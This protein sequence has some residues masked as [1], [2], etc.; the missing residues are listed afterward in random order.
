MFLEELASG[1]RSISSKRNYWFI[2]TYG[3]SVF[4][5][6]HERGYVGIGLNSVPISLI[7]SAAD[8][9]VAQTEELKIFL[10]NR[11]NMILQNATRWS[12]QLVTFYR[13]IVVG[14]VIIIPDENSSHFAIGEVTSDVFQVKKVGTFKDKKG[15]AEQFPQKRRKVNWLRVESR[16]RSYNELRNLLSSHQAVTKANKYRHIIEGRISDVFEI[17]GSTHL[18]I[19]INRDED[20]NA[21]HFQRFLNGLTYFYREFCIDAGIAPNEELYLKITLN[22]KGKSYLKGSFKLAV[23]GLLGI[24]AISNNNEFKAEIEGFTIAGKSDGLLKSLTDFFDA[25]HERQMEKEKF[26]DS[27]RNL[28]ILQKVEEDSPKN[29]SDDSSN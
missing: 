17:D 12:N 14:D 6:F 4:D 25:S 26:Q 2:R 28:E 5:E 3:G 22:S 20:I 8:N 1:V 23:V 13:D 16:D 19:R 10:K 11:Y 15:Q 7:K 27:L 29:G 21:F 9:N 24:I 18:V